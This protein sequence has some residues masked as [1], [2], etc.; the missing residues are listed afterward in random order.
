MY[1]YPEIR[2]SRCEKENVPGSS[3]HNIIVDIVYYADVG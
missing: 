1:N 2:S 3:H